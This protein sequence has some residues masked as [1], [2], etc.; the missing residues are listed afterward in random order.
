MRYILYARKSSNSED[1][2]VQSIGDQ[3]KALRGL[4]EGRG[5]LVI[6]E[7]S[8]SRSAKQPGNRPVFQQMLEAIRSGEADAILCWSVNRLSRNPEESGILMGMLQRG[9]LKVIQTIEREYRPEDNVLLLTFESGVANQYIVD[10][11]KNVRRGMRSK[12][13]KGWYPHR[14]PEG[15]R[16][17]KEDRTIEIDEERFPLIRRAWDLMLTGAYTVPRV[18]NELTAWGYRTRQHKRL[19]GGPISRTALFDLFHNPF[20][21]GMFLHGGELHPGAHRPM[22]TKE[23]F[24]RVQKFLARGTTV[25]SNS[26]EFAFTGLIRCGTCGCAVTAEEKVKRYK[27]TGHSAA[28]RYYHCTGNKGCQKL[29]V[30]EAEIERQILAELKGIHLP[31]EA[32]EW[33]R[34]ALADWEKQGAGAYNAEAL[35][36]SQVLAAARRRRE[37]LFEMREDGEIERDEFT[38]R[39]ARL[40]AEIRE[41]ES[42]GRAAESRRK[43]A[44]SSVENALAFC[45]NAQERFANGDARDRREVACLLAEKYVLTLGRL[46]I[47][48]H[49]LL[50]RMCAFELHDSGS[51]NTKRTQSERL[52]P[53]WLNRPELF[54]RILE[55]VPAHF[56]ATGSAHASEEKAVALSPDAS[57]EQQQPL[58]PASSQA[59]GVG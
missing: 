15:Y 40:D 37:R 31:P 45:S 12:V 6:T 27:S 58:Q 59:V 52:S 34:V 42:A 36:R 50:V 39:K 51:G 23:E 41:I 29:S 30:T 17:N 11:S 49:P 16:N 9:Q 38:E 22:V 3:L 18:K 20:Y 4:A 35:Q 55:G 28:Y 57:G 26:K 43:N 10:L 46:E 25:Q 5:L 47:T 33:A 7:L 14:A 54:T 19:G 1:R 44:R 2:Q 24:D 21:Y 13:E 56:P 48:L 53:S 8:E 32:E